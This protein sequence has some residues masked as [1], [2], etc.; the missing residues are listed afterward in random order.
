MRKILLGEDHPDTLN[1]MANLA[2]LL[3][4]QNRWKEAEELE[5]QVIEKR[6]RVLGEEH[7]DTLV[8]MHNL[9]MTWKSQGRNYDALKLMKDCVLLSK[10]VLGTDHPDTVKSLKRLNEWESEDLKSDEVESDQ[11]ESER[12]TKTLQPGNKDNKTHLRLRHH[13]KALWLRS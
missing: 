6:R 4:S 2:D 8:I 1:S 5:I 11:S 13:L 7:P 9:A 12:P 10:Q 3:F